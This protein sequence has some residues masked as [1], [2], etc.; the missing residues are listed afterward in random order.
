MAP[1]FSIVD[2]GLFGLVPH[3][4]DAEGSVVQSRSLIQ[5]GILQGFCHNIYTAS[6]C[7]VK[8]TGNASG[9]LESSP[10]VSAANLKFTG[11]T[12][13]VLQMISTM[14]KGILITEL[15]GSAASPISGEFSYGALGYWIENGAKVCPIADFTIAGNFFDFL[16]NIE[17]L[18][19]DANYFFPHL[20]G[21]Y[22]GAS[23]L[24]NQ[25]AV[26]GQ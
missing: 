7:D 19:D 16:K 13:P 17:A 22:G 1:N 2:E 23:L 20:F 8:T 9:G 21:S 12:I 6:K 10:Q 4:Y 3:S 5:N 24:V 18:G 11:K 25:L 14:K 15:H 26:S